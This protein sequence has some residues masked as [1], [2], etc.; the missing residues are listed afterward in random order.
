MDN[1]I[2]KSPLSRLGYAGRPILQRIENIMDGDDYQ[3]GS[4]EKD[5]NLQR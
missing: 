1:N 3:R 4:I 5:G 2:T